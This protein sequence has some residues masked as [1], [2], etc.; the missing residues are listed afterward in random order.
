RHL[1]SS[2]YDYL[3]GARLRLA[4][5]PLGAQ[6]SL[7]RAAGYDAAAHSGGL[8]G[9]YYALCSRA[10]PREHKTTPSARGQDLRDVHTGEGNVFLLRRNIHKLEKALIMKPRRELFAL[11]YLG[12]TVTSYADC[13]ARLQAGQLRDT[14]TLE[15]S[16]QVL[17][18]YFAA[19]Q[20][21]H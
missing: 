17:T 14:D 7:A 12:E 13:V 18:V 6:L 16:R 8:R 19:I 10:Y 15:W 9:A 11:A 4:Q 2:A 5:S 20:K 3:R 21:A 1:P